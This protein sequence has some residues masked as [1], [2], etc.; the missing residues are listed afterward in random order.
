MWSWAII[1]F[2][3]DFLCNTEIHSPVILIDNLG[4]GA[5]AH[6][7]QRV[8]FMCTINIVIGR[9]IVIAWRSDDYIGIGGTDDIL[10]VASNAPLGTTVNKSTTVLTLISSNHS[11]NGLLT[12]VTELQLVAS[13]SYP[14]SHLSCRVK[15]VPIRTEIVTFF[16]SLLPGN[17][18]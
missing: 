11:S 13:A 17:A 3:F 12:V 9:A 18:L 7:G 1:N 14:K 15:G 2:Y 4:S 5:M 16:T 10:Q 8:T 6:D